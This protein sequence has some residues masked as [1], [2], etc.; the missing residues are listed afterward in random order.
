MTRRFLILLAALRFNVNAFPDAFN[1]WAEVRN[2]GAG[3]TIDVREFELY[4]NMKRE[5]GR[6]TKEHDRLYDN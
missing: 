6:F 2:K 1:A 5:F 3:D 4:R